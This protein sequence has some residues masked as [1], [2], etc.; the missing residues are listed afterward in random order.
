MIKEKVKA[1]WQLCFNDSEEYVDLY[2]RERY[3]NEVNI[4]IES[5]EEVISALQ[6]LPYPMTFCG[7]TI[8]TGYIS[9]ACTHPDY[10]SKGVM[11]ELLKQTFARLWQKGIPVSTL[12]PA[13]SWLFTY[14]ER[15]GYTPI[16][17]HTR[18]DVNCDLLTPMPGMLCTQTNQFNERHYQYL[19]RKLA[20]LPCAIQHTVE[21]YKVILEALALERD[22]VYVVLQNDRISGLAVAWKTSKG[23]TVDTFLTESKAAGRAL[24]HHIAKI[25][26]C[27]EL[28]L[29]LPPG[30]GEVRIP[31]GMARIIQ[32]ESIL[33]LYAAAHPEVYMEFELFDKNLSANNG[34]YT[35]KDG[36]CQKKE[37]MHPAPLMRLTSG[38][39]A[40]RIFATPQPYMSLM[41]D[42]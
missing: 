1:L 10:R 27:R 37:E 6:A 26:K 39:L 14:Y 12:I 35:L 22:Y 16:F 20:E 33:K 38:E 9:G 2:F 36:S 34:F 4:A 30:K 19:S 11:R 28:T 3:N 17:Y 40:H 24:L 8:Q 29:L 21:D 32:A 7:T 18:R 41:L 5:G 23:L 15:L 13:E 31:F 25:N 42:L